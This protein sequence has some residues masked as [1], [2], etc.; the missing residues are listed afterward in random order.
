VGAQFIAPERRAAR[1]AQRATLL[2]IT[3]RKETDRKGLAKQLEA[4]LFDEGRVAYF[5]G[6]G[7]VVYGVD[8]DIGRDREHRREHIRRLG[9]IANLMLDAGVILIVSAQELSQEELDLIR[10]TVD[11]N[12]IETVWIGDPDVPDIACDLSLP[13]G[14][15]DEQNVEQIRALLLRKGVLFQPW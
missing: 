14:E 9:E 2:I 15:A 3:G 8:A 10:T 6:I 13:A 1:F 7:N 4:R 11:P 5:L 12:R